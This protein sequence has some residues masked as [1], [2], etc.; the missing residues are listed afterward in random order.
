MIPGTPGGTLDLEQM[1]LPGP[2]LVGAQ[3]VRRPAEMTGELCHVQNVAGDGL[4]GVV[5][6]LEIFEQALT[7][8][9]HGKALGFTR[10]AGPEQPCHTQAAGASRHNRHR[11]HNRTRCRTNGSEPGELRKERTPREWRR[12]LNHREAV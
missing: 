8:R 5:A 1:Q 7:Q 6:P 11:R 2:N 10:R 3:L 12:R 4:G 9:C